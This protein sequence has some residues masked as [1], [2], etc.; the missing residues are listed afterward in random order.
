MFP[1]RIYRLDVFCTECVSQQNNRL[2]YNR[3]GVTLIASNDSLRRP[4]T[5]ALPAN[6]V[7]FCI[8]GIRLTESSESSHSIPLCS[9]D[10][11]V[12]PTQYVL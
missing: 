1:A 3:N 9:T 8:H 12:F 5:P 10:V 11:L 2:H 6:R 4:D 7:L